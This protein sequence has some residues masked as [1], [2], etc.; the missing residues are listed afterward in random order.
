MLA[1]AVQT[2]GAQNT[3]SL[4]IYLLDVNGLLKENKGASHGGGGLKARMLKD[5]LLLCGTDTFKGIGYLKTAKVFR[6]IKHLKSDV[7][8]SFCGS[9]F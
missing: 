1:A 7:A 4:E 2:A 5:V 9:I 6:P 3:S 8:D